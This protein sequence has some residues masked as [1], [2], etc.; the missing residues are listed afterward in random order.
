MWWPLAVG[1]A[2]VLGGQALVVGYYCL[3]H[4]VP[5][6][7]PT[8]TEW[9][10]DKVQSPSASE[11][12]R[13]ILQPESFALVFGYLTLSW[14]MGWLRSTYYL[15]DAPY[16]AH[17]VA[18]EVFLQLLAVDLVMFLVHLGEH[19]ARSWYRHSHRYHHAFVKP[20]LL[21]AF[22]GS[23]AD[24]LSLIVAPLAV[25]GRL[26]VHYWSYVAFGT[27]Y[28][29][30]FALIHSE[31]D[32]PWEQRAGRLGVSTSADHFRH[33]KH[34]DCNFGH[35]FTFWDRA[36]GTYRPSARTQP[37]SGPK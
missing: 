16:T 3:R 32:H 25:V 26:P 14:H 11:L 1:L 12:A 5:R 23:V 36:L 27:V 24:T 6:L 4:Y 33:H 20:R 31:F 2:S 17:G 7:R 22:Q 37:G 9:H 13:H 21:H 28:S 30:H 34:F 19:R 35:F 15:P 18:A 10:H 8:S 29:M